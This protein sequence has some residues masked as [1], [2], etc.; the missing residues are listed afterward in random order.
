MVAPASPAIRSSGAVRPGAAGR[1]LGF[2]VVALANLA[3]LLLVSGTPG[4]RALPFLTADAAR[5]APLVMMALILGV[6]V[7]VVNAVVVRRWLRAAG[8]FLIS[9]VAVM[10]LSRLWDVFPFAFHEPVVDWA[11][12][13]RLVVGVGIATCVLSMIVQT[14]VLVRIVVADGAEARYAGSGS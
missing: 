14:V 6:A 4:W 3:L 2:G 12:I 10:M 13:A 1:R 8:D 5:V 11:M 9:T 7:N